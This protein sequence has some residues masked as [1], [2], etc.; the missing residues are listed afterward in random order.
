[1]EEIALLISF[2]EVWFI[3]MYK[4]YELDALL[5]ACSKPLKRAILITPP[6]YLKCSC[7]APYALHITQLYLTSALHAQAAS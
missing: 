3:I 4:V 1:M 5:P 2:L 6:I 7:Q